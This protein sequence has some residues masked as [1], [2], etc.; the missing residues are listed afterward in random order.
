MLA[1]DQLLTDNLE[2]HFV[3]FKPKDVVSGDFYWA[4]PIAN[5]FIFITADCT[6]HGVPGAFMSL[7]NISKLSQVINEN[8]IIRPDIILNN[9]RS[10]II[11]VLNPRGTT[12]ESK[13]GMDAV[14][15]KIDK[16]KMKLEF[17]AVN[18]SFLVIRDKTLLIVRPIK[19]RL[20][21]ATTIILILPTMKWI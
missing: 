15:C 17:A 4:T 20:E 19:C 18:N 2:E 14:L 13:D 16:K 11:K 6:G 7:L 21:K 1:S 12:E 10:E 5:G 9:L 8:K 3:V